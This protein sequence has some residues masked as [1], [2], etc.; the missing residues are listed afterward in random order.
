MSGHQQSAVN[1]GDSD[2]IVEAELVAD[3]E[4]LSAPTVHRSHP[5]R[6]L[7][8]QHTILYPGEAVP[9]EADAPAYTRTDFEVSAGTAQRLRD[10]SR[11]ANTSRNYSSERRKFAG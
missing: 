1:D 3:D 7:V 9:T 8:D 11:P 2:E 4:L 6:P 10:K 5:P